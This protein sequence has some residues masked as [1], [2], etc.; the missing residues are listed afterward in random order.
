MTKM[1]RISAMALAMVFVM[2]MVAGAQDK[3]AA[4]GQDKPAA[5]APPAPPRVPQVPLRIQVVL[6]RYQ[7]EKKISSVPYTLSVTTG[8]GTT[9][10]RM[11]VQVPVPQGMIGGGTPVASYTLHDV[12]TN[13]DCNASVGADA[14]FYRISLVVTDSAV[15]GPT[16]QPTDPSARPSFRNFTSNST[17]L[18]RDGQTAQYTSATDPVSGEVL[19]IEATL[20]VLK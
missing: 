5:S 7:G 3:P 9:S 2:G 10:L 13:I 17:I 12:G 15:F 16:A 8:A 14:G 6:S 1:L 20:T 19:K 11:G 18:L 4:G